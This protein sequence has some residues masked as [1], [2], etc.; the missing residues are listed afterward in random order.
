MKY[1]IMGFSQEKVMEL[2][3]NGCNIDITDLAILNWLEK[4][5][6]SSK[7]VKEVIEGKSY[8]WVN[9]QSL[10]EDMPI[11]GIKKRMLYTRL[12]KMVDI[13]ILSHYIK[14]QGGTFSMYAFNFLYDEL[15]FSENVAKNNAD[16]QQNN[17]DG[18]AKKC[19]EGMQNNAEQNNLSLN[20]P[21]EK[22]PYNKIN[23]ICS[24]SDEP[25]KIRQPS[26]DEIESFFKSVWKLYPSKRGI[27]KI[28]LSK[29]KKLYSYGYE[30]IKRCV[31]RYV[32]EIKEQ[33]KEDYYQNG[34][35]FFN[36]GYVDFLDENYCERPKSNGGGFSANKN[37]SKP[38]AGFGYRELD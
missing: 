34:S 17:A 38:S 18:S 28:S 37:Q 20:N 19:I 30:Q 3:A 33:G 10:L 16:P 15:V 32:K 25:K 24:S 13:G 21:S 5:S 35:T 12:Q 1:S 2:N 8:F 9:Y 7:V 26:Q 14:K 23:I 4:I 29:K 11:L 6:N 22:E 31:E 36:S 27:G